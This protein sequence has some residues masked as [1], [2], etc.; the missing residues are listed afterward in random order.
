VPK[1]FPILIE[2]E[3]IAVGK[4]MRLLNKTAGVAK[5]H[6]NLEQQSHKSNGVSA[7][8]TRGKF[9]ISGRAAVGDLL[10]DKSPQRTAA[11]RDAFAAQ[12]RSPASINSVLNAMLQDKEIS[13][14]A[15]GYALTKKMRDRLRFHR[16]KGRS[17][18][19]S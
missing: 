16:D 17:S 13:Q 12:G 5:L 14:G 8:R 18:K 19:K 9:E 2:V 1:T 11:L 6:L 3:E 7:P 4:V 10:Y 15:D